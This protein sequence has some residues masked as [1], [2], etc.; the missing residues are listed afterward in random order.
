MPVTSKQNAKEGQ[1]ERYK[2]QSDEKSAQPLNL[3]KRASALDEGSLKE[4]IISEN[5]WW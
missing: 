3:C 2:N 4:R 1:R 5:I